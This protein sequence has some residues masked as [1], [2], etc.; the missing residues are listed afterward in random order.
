MKTCR[1][2]NKESVV[3]LSQHRLALCQQH[4]IEWF[5]RRT[6]ETIKKFNMF[7]NKDKILVAVSGGKDSIA[8]W[9]ALNELG[10]KA[11]GLYINLGIAGYSDESEEVSKI[12]AQ[13]KGLKLHIISLQKDLAPIP[14]IKKIEK[15]PTCSFCGQIKRYYINKFAKDMGYTVLATGHNLDDEVSTLFLNVLNWNLEY[16]ARQSP[17]LNEE[18]SFTKKVKPLFKFT[19]EEN[20]LYVSLKKI[21]YINKSCPFSKGATSIGYKQILNAI[22]KQ[23]PG[24]KL[25]FYL[26]FI[27]KFKPILNIPEPK[28]NLCQNCGQLTTAQVCSVCRLKQK[29]ISLQQT[30][31]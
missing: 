2:C 19:E 9:D 7:N 26:D 18:K 16:L 17:V 1:M 29:L 4:Y 12:Y 11:D 15:R 23:S 13:E 31:Y 28:L 22:E 24:T 10:Y 27:K 8:L 21:N 3:Y 25:R 14:Q 30:L 6:Q 5:L 20:L